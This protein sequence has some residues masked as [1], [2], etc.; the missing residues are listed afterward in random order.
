M[1]FRAGA[2][3]VNIDVPQG[4]AGPK[5]FARGGKGTWI[6]VSSNLDGSCVTPYNS[7]PSRE[8]GDVTADV[9]PSVYRDKMKDGTGPAFMN[10]TE[11]SDEDMDYML[12]TA[13][14]SEGIDSLT[15][16]FDQN[17]IDPVSYT[18]LDVYKRQMYV[19]TVRCLT[20][21]K[22]KNWLIKEENY[23]S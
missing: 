15:D 2:K 4:H 11:L 1:G 14:V 22:Q 23:E 13:F 9:W 21:Q 16:Y 18:H 20:I 19:W 7:K 17:G 12:H 5:Y 6:G 10:C 3:L 8:L